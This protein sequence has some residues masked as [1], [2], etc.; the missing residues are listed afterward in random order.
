MSSRVYVDGRIVQL[1]N[2][3]AIVNQALSDLRARRSNI[4]CGKAEVVTTDVSGSAQARVFNEARFQDKMETKD[5]RG[6]QDKLN[7]EVVDYSSTVLPDW[8]PMLGQSIDVDTVQGQG[9]EGMRLVEDF[10]CDAMEVED[11][12]VGVHSARMMVFEV[13]DGLGNTSYQIGLDSLLFDEDMNWK[14]EK[15]KEVYDKF[16]TGVLRAAKHALKDSESSA[17]GGR[18]LAAKLA[19]AGMRL[20]GDEKIEGGKHSIYSRPGQAATTEEHTKTRS[21]GKQE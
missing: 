16:A 7:A 6:L 10:E 15:N 9:V 8:K 2:C 12:A 17:G 13:T 4:S 1:G 20:H 14:S 11:E 5:T 19:K 3:E 21:T 18:G